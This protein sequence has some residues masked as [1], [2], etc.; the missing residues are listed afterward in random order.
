M[1]HVSRSY[2]YYYIPFQKYFKFQEK[3]FLYVFCRPGFEIKVKKM[4]KIIDRIQIIN[5]IKTQINI[6]SKTT[7]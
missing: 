2:S 3:N 6:G 7:I 1:K 4:E 5:Y